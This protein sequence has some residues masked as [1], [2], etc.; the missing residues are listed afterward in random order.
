MHSIELPLV[1]KCCL[2]NKLVDQFYFEHHSNCTSWD[3]TDVEWC[4]GGIQFVN[5]FAGE[6]RDYLSFF[7][8]V[9]GP[10]TQAIYNI[11]T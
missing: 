1:F 10:Y 6:P 8:I 3:G 9:F 2:D 11:M 7:G 5:L 4:V